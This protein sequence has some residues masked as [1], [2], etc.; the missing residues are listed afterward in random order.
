MLFGSKEKKDKKVGAVAHE[1][2][3]TGAFINILIC[4][5][6]MGILRP[7]FPQ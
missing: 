4:I 6:G 3:A 7:P 2:K 5:K 1:V